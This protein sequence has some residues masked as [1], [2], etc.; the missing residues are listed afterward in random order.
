MLTFP[1]AQDRPVLPSLRPTQ[2]ESSLLISW[3]LKGKVAK[4]SRVCQSDVY[5][6]WM[7]NNIGSGHGAQS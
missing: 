3:A 6:F 7:K 2:S 1:K 4:A 5:Y